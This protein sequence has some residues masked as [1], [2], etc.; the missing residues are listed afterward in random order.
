MH[1]DPGTLGVI[2]AISLV[3]LATRFGGVWLMEFVPLTRRV[4]VFLA[5]LATSGL[6]SIVTVAAL[7]GDR[8]SRVAIMLSA[9]LILGGCN[10]ILAIAAAMA[11]AAGLRASGLF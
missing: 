3:T 1:V 10:L 4:E 6:V 11:A 5:H 2:V 7:A 8:V 9:L